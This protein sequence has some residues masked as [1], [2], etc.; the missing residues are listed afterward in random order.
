MP[1]QCHVNM[2]MLR[3]EV[4]D[5]VPFERPVKVRFHARHDVPSEPRQIQT[6]AELRRDD[7]LP[8]PRV[9]AA[10]PGL[11]SWR[12]VYT[13]RARLEAGLFGFEGCI[14]PCDVT[15]VE[16]ASVLPR[17]LWSS[18][19]GQRSAESAATAGAQTDAGCQR[20]RFARTS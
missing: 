17:D 15:A 5:G 9:P 3:V 20:A 1:L 8:Q 16:A 10:L 2:G 4:G 14:L 19:A 13:V 12:D 18:S 11:K 6:L 7:Q